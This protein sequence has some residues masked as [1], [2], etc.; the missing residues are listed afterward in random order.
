MRAVFIGDSVTDCGRFED[1]EHLGQGYVRLLAQSWAAQLDDEGDHDLTVINT[2]T[3]GHRV[4]DLEGR[5][6]VDVVDHAPQLVSIMIG[7]NDMWRRYDDDD[8]TST[9]DY[10]AGYRRLLAHVVDL[11]AQLVLMEPFLLPVRAEQ[12]GWREDLDAKIAVVH[13]L[14]AEHSALLV[15]T[16]RDLNALATSVGA[17]ELATDGIHPTPRGHAAIADLWSRTVLT[18]P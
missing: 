14:A 1:P 7:I 2:G 5:V 17:A 4:P 18:T 6:Q 13:R 15:H 10:E 16:D 12:L 11:G 8:P 3:S 9:E